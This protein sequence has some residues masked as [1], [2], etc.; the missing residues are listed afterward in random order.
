MDGAVR[1]ESSGTRFTTQPC[2]S[3]GQILCGTLIAF[4]PFFVPLCY[5][6]RFFLFRIP[7]VLEK[8]F[9]IDKW[10]CRCLS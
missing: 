1:D 9:G 5:F 3:H 7:F 2:H 4:P 10:C 8:L 6:E